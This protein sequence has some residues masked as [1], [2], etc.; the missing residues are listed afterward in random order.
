MSIG[1]VVDFD[2]DQPT[3]R[4]DGK[5]DVVASV[6]A[7]LPPDDVV[8][9][10]GDGM[11][12]AAA[13]PPADAFIGFGGVVS[14]PAVREATPYFFESFDDMFAFFQEKGVIYDFS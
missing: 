8:L 5:R 2:H 4:S 11:T 10:V 13:C 1:V 6:K 7:K 12:D 14:R 9:M 3:S